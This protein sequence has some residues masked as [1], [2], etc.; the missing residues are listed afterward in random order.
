MP[1]G[2]AHSGHLQRLLGQWTQPRP[3]HLGPGAALWRAVVALAGFERQRGRGRLLF[4]GRPAAL[5]RSRHPL[6]CHPPLGAPACAVVAL[7]PRAIAPFAAVP[8]TRDRYGGPAAVHGGGGD[9]AL[10]TR[11]ATR[12]PKPKP[13]RISRATTVGRAAPPGDLRPGGP[14]G[15]RLVAPDPGRRPG[16]PSAKAAATQA[17]A[18]MTTWGPLAR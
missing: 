13:A 18:A 4:G 12:S 1:G 6:Q 7:P 17:P 2:A 16:A 10:L 3:C 14:G 8:H 9:G 5:T 15:Q 11:A